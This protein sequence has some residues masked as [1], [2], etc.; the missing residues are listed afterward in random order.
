MR[1][2]KTHISDYEKGATRAF[3]ITRERLSVGT[4]RAQSLATKFN[5]RSVPEPFT[6][7]VELVELLTHLRACTH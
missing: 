7:I 3:S 6:A 2:L 5:A 1:R 4:K